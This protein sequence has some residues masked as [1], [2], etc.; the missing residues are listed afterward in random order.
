MSHN[1]NAWDTLSV[2]KTLG[3]PKLLFWKL[4]AYYGPGQSQAG[5]DRASQIL[6]VAHLGPNFLWGRSPRQTFSL[7]QGSALMPCTRLW[8]P[9]KGRS[10]F[11]ASSHNLLPIVLLHVATQIE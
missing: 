1:I 7:K 2:G 8:G 4:Q 6:G 11:V 5:F 3:Q 9:A 10:A